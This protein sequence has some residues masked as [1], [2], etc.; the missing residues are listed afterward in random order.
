MQRMSLRELAPR[1]TIALACAACGGVQEAPEPRP[2]EPIVGLPC[3]D[4]DAV[5]DGLPA[6]LGSRGRI[7][8]ADEPGEPLILEGTVTDAGGRPASGVIVYA[9]HTDARG[10]YPRGAPEL[11]EAARRHGRLRGWVAT[12]ARGRYRIDTIRPGGYRDGSTPSHVHLHVIEVG[13]CTYWVDSVHFADDPRLAPRERE[14]LA[15]GERGGSGLV[16]PR[17]DG[18]GSWVATRDIRLGEGVP[19]YPVQ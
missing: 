17:R 1:W 16:R 11:G 14:Q 2:R 4:C 5:F 7:A 12:D 3:E 13:R 19:G 6:V 10:V 18:Q 9:Y 8:P 15:A